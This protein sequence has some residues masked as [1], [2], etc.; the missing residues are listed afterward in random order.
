MKSLTQST[1]T[2]FTI[3]FCLAAI[4]LS[5]ACPAFAEE[6]GTGTITGSFSNLNHT[7]T[8]EYAYSEDFFRQPS[9]EYNHDLARLSLG[10]A[11]AAFRDREHLQDQDRNLIAYLEAMGFEQIDT[12]PYRTDPT[13]YSIG[14]GLAQ[15]HLDDMTVVA[16]AVCGG[17]YGAEWTSNLTVGDG[18][19]AEGFQDASQKLQAGLKAYM[20]RYPAEGPVKLWITGFSRAAAVSNIT[21]ADCTDSGEFADVYAYTFA[22]PRTTKEP[23]D[24]RNIFNIIQK[25]DMVPKIPLADWGYERYGKDLYLV[26]PEIDI[27]CLDVIKR[28]KDLY[29]DMVGSDMVM[30][31]E[32]NYQLR[33]LTDYLNMLIPDSATYKD[34]LQPL[35]LDIMT[36]NEGT[37]DALTV[38]LQA[39][40]SYSLENHRHI[41]ELRAMIEYL[42]TIINI[43]YLQGGIEEFPRYQWDPQFGTTNLFNDHFPFEYLS[44][45][46]ASD[47]PERLFSENTEYVRLVI[48]GVV[49]ADITDD[50]E[51]LKTVLKDGTELVDGVEDPESLPDVEYSKEKLVITLP[52]DK[53]YTVVIRSRSDL[54]QTVTYTG[55]LYSGNTVRAKADDLYSFL[56]SSGETATITTASN[57]RAIEPDS[58][59]YTDVSN[60]IGTIYSPTT[61]MR[62]ENN[63]VMRL[64]ISGF[65]N[66]ILLILVVLIVEL[67]VYLI[68]EVIRKKKNR[69]RNAVAAFIWHLVNVIIFAILELAMWYFIPVLTIAKFIPGFLA[70]VIIAIYAVKGYRENGRRNL[71]TL[72]IYLAALAVYE[73]LDSLFIGDFTT[74]KALMMLIIYTLF[75][76]AGFIFLWRK[77]KEQK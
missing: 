55:L 5:A 11:L 31:F 40:Q 2:L 70:F 62:L 12:E 7:V 10:M 77:P 41:D 32:I 16:V 46:L 37:Q 50:G 6:N 49:D 28:A 23:G 56:M 17:G 33:T 51:V 38:L 34:Y 71:K 57:G 76:N 65:V 13:S 39:L 30:N 14:Y 75:M 44:M 66:K 54:P 69:K 36:K 59:S 20:D 22:T 15:L 73:I 21:A 18:V 8:W 48:Y 52:A 53:S 4:L 1:V 63:S 25:N 27:D 47:D 45:M 42:E 68:L 67:I 74:W 24:Y 35:I 3:I 60:Y 58:S 43:Y 29:I 64:T 61:A 26:S 72:V 9:D 19:R